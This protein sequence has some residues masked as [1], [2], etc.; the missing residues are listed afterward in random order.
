LKQDQNILTAV[1]N[2][3]AAGDDTARGILYKQYSVAM[4][5]ICIRMTGSGTDAE[6]VLQEAFI[7]AFRNL[8]KVKNPA[9]FGGWLKRI[10]INECI[11]RS[12]EMSRNWHSLDD[13]YDV[14]DD[15]D[16]GWFADID[17]AQLHREIKALPAGC[18]QVFN[19]YAV[20]DYSHKEIADSLGISES[21]SKSQYQRARQLLRERLTKKLL[22]HG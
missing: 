6:D 3:A 21:T 18:R 22:M 2:N 15:N 11:K 17:M 16:G 14:P 20:E 8:D 10:V 12:K 19:L 1:L 9:A 5:N 7:L 13:N 4:Y